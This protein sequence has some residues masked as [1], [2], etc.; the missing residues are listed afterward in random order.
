[1]IFVSMVLVMGL[2]IL[3]VMF[4]LKVVVSVFYRFLMLL[5]IIIM[6]ELMMQDWFRL[7]FMLVSCVRVILVILVMLELRLK[8]S[9]LMCLL[10]MFMVWVV[11][12]FWLMVCICRLRWVFFSISCRVKNMISVNMMM[13][14]WLQVSEKIGLICKVLFIQFGVIMV[15]LSGEKISCIVCCRIRLMLKVVSRVFSGCL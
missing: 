7:G 13:Q 6:K 11:V 2:M 14:S 5:N 12:W 3:L 10:W 15:W 4:R 9:V 8:V 1:M